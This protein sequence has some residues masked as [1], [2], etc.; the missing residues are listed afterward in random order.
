MRCG[1]AQDTFEELEYFKSRI[2]KYKAVHQLVLGCN[3]CQLRQVCILPYYFLLFLCR[4]LPKIWIHCHW[5][6]PKDAERAYIAIW[7]QHSALKDNLVTG[8]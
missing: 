6:C 5:G 3:T 7:R 1:V 2:S 4:L 8:E